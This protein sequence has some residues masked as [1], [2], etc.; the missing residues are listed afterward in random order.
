MWNWE[1]PDWPNFSWDENRLRKA[2]EEFLKGSGIATGSLRHLAEPDRSELVIQTMS[3]EAVTTSEIEGEILDRAS[4]QSSLRRQFGLAA[5][6]RRVGQAEEGIAEM[7]VDLYRTFSEPL[8]DDALP[9]ARNTTEGSPRS[10]TCG[11][12]SRGS[13]PNASRFGSALRAENPLRSAAF[14]KNP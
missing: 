11:P 10:Q 6:R 2:E 12:L 9:M 3:A 14:P 5:D 1:Q 13:R 4:V 7:M 8:S